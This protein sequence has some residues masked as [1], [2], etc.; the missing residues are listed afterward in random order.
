MA[1]SSISAHVDADPDAVFTTLTDAHRLPTWNAAILRVIEAPPT[2][3]EGAEWVVEMHALGRRW[4][5]RGRVL[6]LDPTTRTFRH[7]SCTDDGNPSYVDW[8]W[9]VTAH[10]QGGSQV[11]VSWDLHPQ[12][13]WRRVLFVHIRRRQLAHTELPTSLAALGTAARNMVAHD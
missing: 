12:T 8:T 10:K 5:S 4:H 9:T 7:R 3:T 2:L 6:A 11:T 1:A 13:F